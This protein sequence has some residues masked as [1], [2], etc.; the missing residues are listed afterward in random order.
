MLFLKNRECSALDHPAAML[1]HHVNAK[2]SQNVGKFVGVTL[3][4]IQIVGRQ[5]RRSNDS[6]DPVRSSHNDRNEVP[7]IA[8]FV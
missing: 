2:Q 7:T 8:I 4:R 1:N 5:I 3:R 6:D